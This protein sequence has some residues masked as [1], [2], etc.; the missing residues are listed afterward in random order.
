MANKTS[1]LVQVNI[2]GRRYSLNTTDNPEDLHRLAESLT[3]RILRIRR[4]TGASTLDCITVAAM[5]LADERNQLASRCQTLE[6]RLASRRNKTEAQAAR[7]TQAAPE[8][9]TRAGAQP[10]PKKQPEKQPEK[11]TAEPTALDPPPAPAAGD[12]AER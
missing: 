2:A 4:E 8:N 10:E 1:Q 12:A 7:K 6:A 9:Q 3:A 11:S 5:E